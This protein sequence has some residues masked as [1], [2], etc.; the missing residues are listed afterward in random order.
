MTFDLMRIGWPNTA[1]ILALAI[2]PI[3]ALTTVADRRPAAAQVEQIEAATICLTPVGVRG[4]RGS[5]PRP[6]IVLE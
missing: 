2:M 5:P 6:E 4:G 1:A 3:V